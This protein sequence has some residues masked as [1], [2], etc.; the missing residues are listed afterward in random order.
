MNGIVRE[1]NEDRMIIEYDDGSYEYVDLSEKVEKNSSSGFYI[2]LKL[3]TDLKEGKKVKAGEV[4]AYDKSSFSN[5][6]G[7]TDNIAYNIGTFCKFAILNTD[8]GFEDSTS[9]SNWL[10]EDLSDAMTSDVILQIDKV[11][12]KNTNIYNMVQ[13]GQSIEEGDTLLIAQTAYDEEDV[14]TLVRN[15]TADDEGDITELGRVPIKSKVTGVV[16]DIKIYRTVDID[17]L[18]PTLKKIVTKYEKEIEAKK[19]E[20]RKYGVDNIETLVGSTGK[21][22]ANGRLKN[23]DDGVKIEFYLKYED[24]MSVG[25]KLIY[26]SADNG[27]IKDIFPRGKEPKSSFRPKEKIHALL[28]SGS[29]DG[30]MVCSIMVNGAINKGLVELSRKCKDLL[31]IKYNDDLFTE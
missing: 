27:V 24:R 10:S 30:R 13:K 12:N 28:S 5:D 7:A 16:Q 26:Y 14:N 19:K 9:V 2:T 23:A 31:G 18:S 6:I 1:I 11:F 8:E 4:I 21:L 25:D 22:P 15:L 29:V 3:D 20:M 17:E